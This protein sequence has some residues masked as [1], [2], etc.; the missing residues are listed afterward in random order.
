[1]SVRSV[2]IALAIIILTLPISLSS[3]ID[4][5]LLTE[6][7]GSCHIGHGM[8]G[9]PM[10]AA[11]EEQ[12]CYQCHGS[13]NNRDNMVRNGKLS[14]AARLADIEREFD[15]VYRHPVENTAS[16]SPV[17]II[18]RADGAAAD[19]AECVDCHSPHLRSG[20]PHKQRNSVSGVTATGQYIE[21]ATQEYEVCLKCHSD[22]EG[23]RDEKK[24]IRRQFESSA[25]SMHPVSRS[26]RATGQP[27]LSASPIMSSGMTCTD[28]HT[29]DDP[30]GP[31]GPHGSN[32]KHLLS[33]NYEQ[34]GYATESPLAY[35]FCYSC[36]ERSS[37]LGNESFPLHREHIVGDPLTGRAG[38]SCYTCHSAH[39]SQ[40][41]PFLINFNEDVVTGSKIGNRIAY[42]S[43]G[44]E[45][46][47]CYLSCHGYD[48]DPER[49]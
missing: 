33:G 37:I 31:R 29:N 48:H 13:A 40:R 28:C 35:E 36:H 1:M 24:N 22:N 38:T 11:S 47:E 39:S 10:L 43:F 4:S 2:K 20:D 41:N 17:E 7:C 25:K 9:E 14:G 15:K 18:P 19:H 21:R 45:R 27:S 49:Y 8:S 46:G 16:H 12:F 44:I 34:G 42:Q 32:N 3:H 30:N 5:P 23:I 6:G 26:G